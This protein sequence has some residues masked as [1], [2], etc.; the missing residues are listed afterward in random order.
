MQTYAVHIE[1]MGIQ[2]KHVDFAEKYFSFTAATVNPDRLREVLVDS[3]VR[4]IW[5]SAV[6]LIPLPQF[7]TQVLTSPLN[8]E[9]SISRPVAKRDCFLHRSP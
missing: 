2:K 7:Y 6:E 9:R 1:E 8:A 3:M 5:T 4:L